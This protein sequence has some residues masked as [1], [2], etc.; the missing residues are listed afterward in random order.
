MRRYW[1]WC[2]NT[3]AADAVAD[4]DVDA[5]ADANAADANAAD[6]NAADVADAADAADA[7]DADAEHAVMLMLILVLILWPLAVAPGVPLYLLFS[8]GI[9]FVSGDPRTA[10]GSEWGYCFGWTKQCNSCMSGPGEET[11]YIYR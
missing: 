7:D 4:P 9:Y 10:E 8:S 6:A 1:C 11:C 5:D 3:D 2:I